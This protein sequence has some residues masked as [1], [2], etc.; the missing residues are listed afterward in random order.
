M[1]LAIQQLGMYEEAFVWHEKNIQ[2]L[3]E[4]G[5]G[6]KDDGV[7]LAIAFVNKSWALRKTRRLEEVE[8]MLEWVL[9]TVE[10][11]LEEN[12]Q[13]FQAWSA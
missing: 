11:A 9:G 2:I 13:V 5:G 8:E 12:G 7:G 3:L 1:A 10:L 6:G 4:Y